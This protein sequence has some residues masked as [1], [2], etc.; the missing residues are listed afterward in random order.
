MNTSGVETDGIE[1]ADTPPLV[2]GAD[3]PIVKAQ[4]ASS[5]R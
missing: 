3:E 1:A 4:A 2:P 5:R